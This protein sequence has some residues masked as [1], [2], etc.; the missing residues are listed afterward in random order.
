MDI[1]YENRR[2]SPQQFPLWDS[3]TIILA[4]SFQALTGIPFCN[5]F[6]FMVFPPNGRG[7]YAA[8]PSW[9][10]PRAPQ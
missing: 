9:L 8:L 1:T 10:L 6:V 5:S 7:G 2:V 4:L 3:P